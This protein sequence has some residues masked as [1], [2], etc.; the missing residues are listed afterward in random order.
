MALSTVDAGRRTAEHVLKNGH[1]LMLY[2]GGEAEQLSQQYDQ[3]VVL[4]C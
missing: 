4:H 2:P 1:N 3:Y